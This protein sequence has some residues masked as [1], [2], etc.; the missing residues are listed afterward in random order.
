VVAGVILALAG[1]ATYLTVSSTLS[2][3]RTTTSPDA[4][5]AD[6]DFAGPFTAYREALAINEHTLTATGGKTCA[7]LE[8]DDPLR[9]TAMQGAFPQGSLFTSVVA[10]GIAALAV[11]LGVLFFLVGLA[12]LKV[13]QV[14]RAR[15]QESTPL[16]I[17]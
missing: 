17:P 8:R 6:R 5:L 1:V 11:G 12:L 9:E 13:A 16:S 3:E 7:E 4:C 2:D 10:F 15:D 14:V